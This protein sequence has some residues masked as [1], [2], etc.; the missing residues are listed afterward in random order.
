L[1]QI[2]LCLSNSIVDEY[3]DVLRRILKEEDELGELLSLF[4]RRVNIVFATKTPRIKI[5]KK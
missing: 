2:T 4:S 1:I 5:I 3:I